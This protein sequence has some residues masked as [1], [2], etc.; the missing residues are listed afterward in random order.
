MCRKVLLVDFES[1]LL[2]PLKA[3]LEA[4]GHEVTTAEDDSTALG[5]IQADRPD[6]ILYDLHFPSVGG[7]EFCRKVRDRPEW[8]EIYLVV[9]TS[10][11]QDPDVQQATEIGVQLLLP[12]PFPPGK[13]LNALQNGR[14]D[15]SPSP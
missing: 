9:L 8:T 15:P 2:I 10:A 13:L 4:A 6:A 14:A 1:I 5:Q 7:L 11:P 3:F 12:K